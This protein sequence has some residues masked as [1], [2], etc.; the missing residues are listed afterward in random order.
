[1]LILSAGRGAA[2]CSSGAAVRRRRRRRGSLRWRHRWPRWSSSL[3]VG[4]SVRATAG[5]RR[6]IATVAGRAA[7][8]ASRYHW[9]TYANASAE[10]GGRPAAAI[11]FLLGLDGISLALIVLTTL[12]TV[13]CVLISWE[14]IRE[15]AAGFY[16][17]L[18]LLEAGLIGVFCAFDLVLF[19][20]FFEF[21]LM[22]L[23]FLIGIWGGPQRRYAAVK[24]FLYTLAGSLVTL[25]GLVALVLAASSGGRGDAILRFPSLAAWLTANPLSHEW[26]VALFLAIAVG[27]HD[28]GAG[29]SAAHVV[30]AGA[31]RGADGRQRAAWPA[32]C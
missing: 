30:A 9:F 19:Y 13:S 15:R 25:V 7:V 2:C 31:R 20:V 3:A 1:M 18:L 32:C 23:F 17:C 5:A 26:Q 22:P 28:Q 10:R 27:L 4:V 14:S 11:R 16:A 24:F 8:T 21:T 6:T 12:L 29:V